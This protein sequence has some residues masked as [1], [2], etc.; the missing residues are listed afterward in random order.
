M[1]YTFSFNS[2]PPSGFS[3]NAATGL[4]TIAATAS[5]FT[6][7]LS[8]RVS[9]GVSTDI[10]SIPVNLVAPIVVPLISSVSRSIYSC[11]GQMGGGVVAVTPV[12]YQSGGEM[13]AAILEIGKNITTYETGKGQWI[14][15]I[16]DA[17]PVGVVEV[18]IN[19]GGGGTYGIGET[20]QLTASVEIDYDSSG[21]NQSVTWSIVSGAYS[22]YGSVS[23]SGL[24]TVLNGEFYAG[25]AIFQVKATS[26]AYPGYSD[27]FEVY[28]ISK[29]TSV[30]LT[31]SRTTVADG[32]TFTIA[33]RLN[34]S[35]PG[36]EVNAPNLQYVNVVVNEG[37]NYSY[38]SGATVN[39]T[40]GAG[41]QDII[42][43]A[44]YYYYVAGYTVSTV[45]PIV[46]QK[47]A[48][49]SGLTLVPSYAVTKTGGTSWESLSW[50]TLN[51]DDRLTGAAVGDGTGQPTIVINL[52]SA[53]TVKKIILAGGD[54]DA[55]FSPEVAP[56]LNGG[57]LEY[58]NNA[59]ATWTTHTT[60]SGVVD[61]P[62][63]FKEYNLDVTAQY[64]RIRR[65]EYVATTSFKF[66]TQENP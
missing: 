28:A 64:W 6:G 46:I 23:S 45:A 31:P 25:D 38:L 53:L 7:N 20:I 1:A 27:I 4:I 35:G 49:P 9:D 32:E 50:A 39:Y 30:A 16:E 63:T 57:F 66:Y 51:D 40:A 14:S 58:S 56:Y 17:Q 11:G 12:L 15:S 24:V 47:A 33:A 26:I 10:K 62:N 54:F 34:G 41:T 55:N 44:T 36:T 3:I 29:F 52:G 18:S 60:I 37:G 21:V 13:Q 22:S 59:G 61:T 5:P 19:Q 8:V 65:L 48:T 42:I 43:T 2:P